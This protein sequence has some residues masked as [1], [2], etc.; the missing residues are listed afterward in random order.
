MYLHDTYKIK[1]DVS[2]CKSKETDS[3][4]IQTKNWKLIKWNNTFRC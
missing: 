2:D 4:K 3:F 1:T